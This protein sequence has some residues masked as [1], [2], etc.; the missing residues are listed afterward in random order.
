M[1]GSVAFAG[2]AIEHRCAM[3]ANELPLLGT[4]LTPY[5]ALVSIDAWM[6]EASRQV[7]R[8]ER[9]LHY[10]A[11]A[12][13]LG[14]LFAVFSRANLFALVLFGAFATLTVWDEIGFHRGLAAK[15]RRV[16]VAAYAA[17]VFFLCVWGWLERAS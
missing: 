6:H 3:L 2:S 11:G 16:H 5:L 10:S 13:F 1:L 15:E 7:P 14:F 4:A 17:L 12:I 8:V 9:W